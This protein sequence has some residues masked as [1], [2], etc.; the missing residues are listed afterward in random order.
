MLVNVGKCLR[1]YDFEKTLEDDRT[2]AKFVFL[3]TNPFEDDYHHAEKYAQVKTQDTLKQKKWLEQT[4]K[5][6]LP[7]GIL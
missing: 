2:T 6:L 3:D 1:C 4:L 5:I 7:I